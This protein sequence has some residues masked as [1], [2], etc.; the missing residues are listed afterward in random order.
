MNASDIIKRKQEN[1]LLR[2]TGVNG[3]C[4]DNY[5]FNYSLILTDKPKI[6]PNIVF[7]QGTKFTSKCCLP[8]N[9]QQLQE[10]IPQ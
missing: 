10:Q 1:T 3:E 2:P 4:C 7:Y 5:K 8:N 6:C 9:T